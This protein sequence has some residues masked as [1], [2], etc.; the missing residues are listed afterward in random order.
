MIPKIVPQKIQV[1][2]TEIEKDGRRFFCKYSDVPVNA[3]GW[4]VDLKYFPISFDLVQLNIHGAP[5]ILTGWWNGKKWV[6]L[7]VK[8]NASI[9]AWK[10][11]I[12]YEYYTV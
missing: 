6:G 2:S 1:E 12:N 11:I 10:R 7:R 9:N 5:K 8:K 4:V 3:Q